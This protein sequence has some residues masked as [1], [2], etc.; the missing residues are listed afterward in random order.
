[1]YTFLG[2]KLYCVG[3]NVICQVAFGA[4]CLYPIII[5]MEKFGPIANCIWE[6]WSNGVWLR[7]GE[8]F[9]CSLLDCRGLTKAAWCPFLDL[10][11][12]LWEREDQGLKHQQLCSLLL[13][14]GNM[15]LFNKPDLITALP[16]SFSFFYLF[17]LFT[18]KFTFLTSWK[19][20]VHIYCYNFLNIFNG[21]S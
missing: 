6:I 19:G 14:C 1:M 2:R 13:Y 8:R 3:C 9:S 16:S 15:Y 21:Q 12:C 4:I 17:N 5:L 7:T 11:D 18:L 20:L 10:S